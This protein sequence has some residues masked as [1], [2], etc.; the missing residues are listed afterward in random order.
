LEFPGIIVTRFGKRKKRQNR[1]IT[2]SVPLPLI[3]RRAMAGRRRCERHLCGCSPR[4]TGGVG[5][6]RRSV[7]YRARGAAGGSA[8]ACRHPEGVGES[9]MH[10]LKIKVTVCELGR[11]RMAA[12]TADGRRDV[13]QAQCLKARL[14]RI[15]GA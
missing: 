13:L 7:P 9:L 8:G 5:L 4:P 6:D 11:D 3:Y 1:S 14:G 12:G 10:R 15:A 2:I